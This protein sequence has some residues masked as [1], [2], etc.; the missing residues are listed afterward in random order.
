MT[1]L[2]DVS[3]PVGGDDE[4]Q[5]KLLTNG[6]VELEL[7]RFADTLNRD[8]RA[9]AERGAVRTRREA[10]ACH[11]RALRAGNALKQPESG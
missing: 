9:H 11:S 6:T 4:L 3:G 2:S 7:P 1:S 10:P 8:G 5:T